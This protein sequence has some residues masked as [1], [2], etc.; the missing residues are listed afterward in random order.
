MYIPCV[1][2]S[3]H[4]I[5]ILFVLIIIWGENRK[6]QMKAVAIYEETRG[7]HRTRLNEANNVEHL[8][9]ELLRQEERIKE[10]RAAI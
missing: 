7:S 4:I 9:L 10:L 1:V 5:T 2:A 6:K 8:H 3:Y